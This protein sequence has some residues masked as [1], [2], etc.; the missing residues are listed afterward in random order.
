ML[1]GHALRRIRLTCKC[2]LSLSWGC[3]FLFQ[4]TDVAGTPRW[5]RECCVCNCSGDD[6]LIRRFALNKLVRVTESV[7]GKNAYRKDQGMTSA[8]L[9]DSGAGCASIHSEHWPTAGSCCCYEQQVSLDDLSLNQIFH[10]PMAM[11]GSHSHNMYRLSHSGQA[12]VRG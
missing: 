9:A 1:Q 5:G 6:S 7:L 8:H 2:E 4:Q 3:A 10:F 12:A 11:R